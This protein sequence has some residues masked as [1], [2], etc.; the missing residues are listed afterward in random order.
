[1]LGIRNIFLLVANG[2]GKADINPFATYIQVSLSPRDLATSMNY[3]IMKWVGPTS[4]V[5]C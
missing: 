2:K 3:T 4:H 5:F 1:M